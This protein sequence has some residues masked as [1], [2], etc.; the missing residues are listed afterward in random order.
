MN[1]VLILGEMKEGSLDMKSLELMG[2]GKKLASDLGAT[3]AVAL[4]GEEVSAGAE[5]AAFYGPNKVFKLE[6]PLLKGFNP[7]LW[8]SSLEQACKQI[9]PK[10]FLMSHGHIGMELGPRL[11]FRLNT[12]L[13]TDCIGLAID[14]DDGLLLRRKPV[15]GGNAIS[16][17]KCPG[18][19]QLVTVRGKVFEPAE[20]GDVTGEI[21]GMAPEIDKAMIRVES[22]EV[23]KEDVVSLDKADVIIAGGAGLDDEDGFEILQEL[24]EILSRSF[25]RVMIGCSRVAVDKGWISSDHQVGLTGSMISPDIYVAVGI[26]GAIQHLV[27]MIQSKKIIAINTDQSCNMFKV[28]DYGV[29][30]DYEKVIPALVERLEELS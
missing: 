13:T 17:F 14:P 30:E 26:S 28:A 15:S 1:D 12:R 20:A 3:L 25:G 29:V 5:E 6:H 16:V 23:V 18:D 24:A 11:A 7:D 8:L 10:I 19:P 27:G 21:V 4:L 2:V 9:N 22:V